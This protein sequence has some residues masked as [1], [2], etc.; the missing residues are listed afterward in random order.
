MNWTTHEDG[1]VL[2]SDPERFVVYRIG[3]AAQAKLFGSEPRWILVDPDAMKHYGE[4]SNPEVL[5][6]RAEAVVT[7]EEAAQGR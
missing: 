1:A 4:H 2:R 5:K 6:A 7:A 3:E